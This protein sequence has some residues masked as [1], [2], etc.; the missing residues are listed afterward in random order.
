MYRP[1]VTR[2][3]RER[4]RVTG[5]LGGRLAGLTLPKQVLLLA[6]WPFLEQ[7]LGF[8]V[9]TV[10]LVLAT[11][12][13]DGIER[14]AILDALGLGGYAVWLMMLVQGAVGTGVMALVSR[15]A[16]A[17]NQEEAT[18]GLS[19]GLMVGFLTGA[20]A[21]L[22]IRLLLDSLIGVFGLTEAATAHAHDYLS[23]LVLI[24]PIIGTMLAATNA[25]RAIGDT[26][27]PFLAMVVVNLVNV[28]LS[29]LLVLGPEP[30]GDMG[31]RGLAWG[32]VIGWLAGLAT[33]LAILWK[34]RL[35]KGDGVGLSLRACRFRPHWHTM[36]RIARVGIP[37]AA[38]MFGMWLIHSVTLNYIARL[39]VSG[40]MGAHFIAIRIESLSFLPGFAIGTAGATLVGQYLGAE[41]PDKAARA[42]RM[43]WKFAAIFMGLIG[44]AF[45]I[46]PE[47]MVRLILPASDA[48]AEA[49]INRATPLIVL[50]GVMQPILAT[51]MV[52]KIC[53]RGAGATRT[54][55][56]GA[57]ASM[58]FFRIILVAI[59][60][61][62]FHFDLL[63]IWILMF[64]DITV[65]AVVFTWIHFRGGWKETVV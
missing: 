7:I 39:A 34:M 53:L 20:A 28:F 57:F 35:A 21:G 63:G 38:E 49:V 61:Q 40:T 6:L 17:R 23:V 65:Q 47:A 54:V 33:V 1:G 64:C 9:A 60:V 41:N 4:A 15:A 3:A 24:C 46:W 37:Q 44:L 45:L 14:V 59:G 5:E 13:S 51:C 36:R 62:V 19:Q 12:M 31:V 48:E 43:C 58:I 56:K 22:I 11:R 2:E 52:M 29:W 25:L 16:G 55:M 30:F 27:S 32:T 18:E 42:V 8:L 50:C 26:L 10:D